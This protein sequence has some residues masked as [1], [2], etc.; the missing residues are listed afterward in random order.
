MEQ[1][2]A[3]SP[4]AYV[5]RSVVKFLHVAVLHEEDYAVGSLGYGALVS[6][7]ERPLQTRRQ[8]H[9][10]SSLSQVL[11]S[12]EPV[13]NMCVHEWVGRL[14]IRSQCAMN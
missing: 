8:A 4:R 3:H 1:A 9:C 6:L 5:Q 14:S 12:S 2:G 13:G 11:G 7:A 10:P